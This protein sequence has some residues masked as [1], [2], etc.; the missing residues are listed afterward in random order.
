MPG[1]AAFRSNMA[2]LV[3]MFSN[4]GVSMNNYGSRDQNSHFDIFEEENLEDFDELDDEQN[5]ME[6]NETQPTGLNASG[7]NTH[8]EPLML[9]K[10]LYRTLKQWSTY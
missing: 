5:E 8:G 6:R 10:T 4:F 2:H 3:S 7:G 9:P 1:V